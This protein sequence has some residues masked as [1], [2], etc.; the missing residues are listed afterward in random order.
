MMRILALVPGGIGDQILFFP[1]L[2]SLKQSYPDAEIDVVVEPGS[3]G[4]YRVC[5]SVENT[6]AFNF[7]DRNSLADWSNLLGTIRDREYEAVLYLGQQFSIGFLLW[8]TGIPTRVGYAGNA[9]SPF[10]THPLPLKTEQYATHMYYDLLQG[11]GIAVPCPD[12]SL[13]VPQPDIQWSE[14][15]QKRLG[16]QDSGYVL[17]HSG[18]SQEKDSYPVEHWQAIIQAFQQRQ[19]QLP[20]V[21]L[22]GADDGAQIA[23][24]S[25]TCPDVKVSAPNDVGKL[26]ATIAAANLMLCLESDALHLAVAVQVP[27]VALCGPTHAKKLLPGNDKFLA[28]QS[29]TGKTA[30]IEPQ[31]VLERLWPG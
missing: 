17:I 15:E 28:I 5:Q 25:Q 13:N 30:D 9:A 6:I 22:Q 26:A 12:L 16:I 20:I 1:T 4:A 29:P 7:K 19:P 23:A 21:L 3:K 27:T 18:S 8:L 11:L 10:L 2:H 14:A 31:K 24:L